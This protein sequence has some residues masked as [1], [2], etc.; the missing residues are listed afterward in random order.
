MLDAN[1]RPDNPAWRCLAIGLPTVEEFCVEGGMDIGCE[2]EKMFRVA[3]RPR[4]DPP[5][6][7]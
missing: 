5:K 7:N 2:S 1:F 3:W 6:H 4:S